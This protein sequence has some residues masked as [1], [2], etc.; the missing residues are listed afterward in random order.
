MTVKLHETF[1]MPISGATADFKLAP[2]DE[3]TMLTLD[4]SYTLNRLGRPTKGFRGKQMR[5]GM[6]GLTQ[7]LP[8]ES[9]RVAAS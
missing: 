7:D 1:K 5:N 2:N 4:Y 9:E 8:R 3:G 6:G